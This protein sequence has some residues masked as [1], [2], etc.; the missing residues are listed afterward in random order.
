M[1]RPATMRR[2]AIRQRWEE[3]PFQGGLLGMVSVALA[4]AATGV[5]CALI[6]L[7]V[8]LVY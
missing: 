8:S 2:A 6:A 5:A 7:V 3:S 1:P 4:T